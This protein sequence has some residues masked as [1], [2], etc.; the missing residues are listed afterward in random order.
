[1]YTSSLGTTCITSWG[2][3]CYTCITPGNT[4][5]IALAESSFLS[6]GR[7]TS[8]AQSSPVVNVHNLWEQWAPMGHSRLNEQKEHKR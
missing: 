5:R 8:E 2:I 4:L 1:M 6:Y 7:L 3:P